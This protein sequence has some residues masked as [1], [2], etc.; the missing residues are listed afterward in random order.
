M[1]SGEIFIRF[2]DVTMEQY[3]QYYHRSDFLSY[4]TYVFVMVAFAVA[5]SYRDWL[6]LGLT[7]SFFSIIALRTFMSLSLITLLYLFWKRKMSVSWLDIVT[8]LGYTFLVVNNY[9]IGMIRITA[10]PEGSYALFPLIGTVYLLLYY[11]LVPIENHWL[12]IAPSCGFLIV[13]AL[14]TWSSA[15][16]A[17]SQLIIFSSA[18][19]INLL[20]AYVSIK[21]F[22]QRRKIFR[23]FL[24]EQEMKIQTLRNAKMEK[25]LQ[26]NERMLVQYEAE[27]KVLNAQIKPHFLFN[28]IAAANA[29]FHTNPELASTLMEKL[30]VYLKYA[31]NSDMEKVTL[32]EE[33]EVVQAYLYI[34]NI[35]M[36]ERL[37]FVIRR[38]YSTDAEIPFCAIQTLVENAVMHGLQDCEAGGEIR[39]N[40]VEKPS[41]LQVSIRDNG[42][43]MN[44]E[45]VRKLLE[46][47]RPTAGPGKKRSI[48]LW[49]LNRRLQLLGSTGLQLWSEKGDGTEVGYEL[50]LQCCA[51]KIGSDSFPMSSGSSHA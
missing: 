2:D 49:N 20:G 23:L 31:V 40:V 9:V 1:N 27:L 35:R 16:E 22:E 21:L 18:V 36:G 42:K 38:E 47:T 5:F 30:S 17:N 41:A 14:H 11:L 48:G 24:Y 28:V 3:R 25:Q 37:N 44:V 39:V 51:D 46:E 19:M 33:L 8:S 50:P 10:Y 6:K 29:L 32:S 34:Q 12:R 4:A 13:T 45:Q 7:G 43:G 26:E 15:G